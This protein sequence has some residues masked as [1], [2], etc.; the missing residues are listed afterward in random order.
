MLIHPAGLPDSVWPTGHNVELADQPLQT[1]GCKEATFASVPVL[2]SP[3]PDGFFLTHRCISYLTQYSDD[4]AGLDSRVAD[5]SGCDVRLLFV[6]MNRTPQCVK[7]G[8]AF[9]RSGPFGT[10]PDP[11]GP[12][13]FDR[14]MKS[15]VERIGLEKL[16]KNARICAENERKKQ[17]GE[18]EV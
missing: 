13:Q 9:I 7:I 14:L 6:P 11:N 4:F 2:P 5:G 12:R 15:C 8:L 17:I 18:K 3:E 1:D 10:Q 16:K